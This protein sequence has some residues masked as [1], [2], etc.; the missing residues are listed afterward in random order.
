MGSELL[1]L[2]PCLLV[3]VAAEAW[4]R[5]KK[6]HV[7]IRKTLTRYGF[8]AIGVATALGLF[9]PSCACRTLPLTVSLILG[10]LLLAPAVSLLVASPLMSPEGCLLAVKNLGFAVAGAEVAAATHQQ[11]VLDSRQGLLRAGRGSMAHRGPVCGMPPQRDVPCDSLP[12]T[13]AGERE[14]PETTGGRP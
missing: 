3:G 9:G 8:A 12:A 4:S 5:A 2:L 7:K 13:H 11:G 1:D 10:G 6:R 14:S